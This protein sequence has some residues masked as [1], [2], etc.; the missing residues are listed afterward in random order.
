MTPSPSPASRLASRYVSWLLPGC[1]KTRG[2][3]ALQARPLSGYLGFVP[4]PEVS[5]G[6]QER[7]H[8]SL[9]RWYSAPLV[10]SILRVHCR[11]SREVRPI[12]ISRSQ[13]VTDMRWCFA[14]VRRVLLA[15]IKNLGHCPCPSCLVRKSDIRKVGMK[16]DMNTRESKLRIDS[17][18][19]RTEVED[20]RRAIYE[21]GVPV[22]AARIDDILKNSAVP[23]RVRS[24]FSFNAL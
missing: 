5:G 17:G 9:R 12:S 14:F 4:L 2:F 13:L 21:A 18:P 3:D 20:A 19:R 22:N 15:N 16:S 7:I 11:L 1:R 24:S 23:T 8:R 10:H 6:L